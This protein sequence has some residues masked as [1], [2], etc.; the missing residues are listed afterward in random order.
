MVNNEIK[1]ITAVIIPFLICQDLGTCPHKR[2][3]TPT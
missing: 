3:M 1:I 2:V